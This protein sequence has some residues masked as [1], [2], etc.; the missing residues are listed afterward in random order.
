M[1][2]I[3]DFHTIK[4]TNIE[5]VHRN[6]FNRLSKV[7]KIA[8]TYQFVIHYF[9][10]RGSRKRWRWPNW[11]KLQTRI[12]REEQKQEDKCHLE[13]LHFASCFQWKTQIFLSKNT[14]LLKNDD[15]P[16]MIK[17]FYEKDPSPTKLLLNFFLKS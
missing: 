12:I 11:S 2:Y 16:P 15:L 13:F 4:R 5:N 17:K 6:S 1:K 14:K 10:G 7:L 3:Y 8:K 9:Y